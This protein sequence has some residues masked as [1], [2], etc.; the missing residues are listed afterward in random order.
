IHFDG[1]RLSV[2]SNKVSIYFSNYRG[3]IYGLRQLY[4]LLS[5]SNTVVTLPV[6]CIDDYPSFPLR[7]VIEG[8][9][10]EPYTFQTRLSVLEFLNKYRYN[11][12]FYAPKDEPC[13]RAEWRKPYV[14]DKLSEIESLNARSKQLNIDFYFC[15]SPGLDFNF[16][17]ECDYSALKA[18]LRQVLDLGVTHFCLLMDDIK[19]VLTEEEGQKFSTVAESQSFLAN[20]MEQYLKCIDSES[21]FIFCPTEYMQ[22]FD[23][24][25]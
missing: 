19:A 18:K 8:F 4:S 5:V 23:T 20:A 25:Y 2:L 13:H 17:N 16:C 24:P 12:Y 6:I 10:G 3:A 7:G 11:A 14:S 21:Q 9:Y 1:Y 15:I 22:N